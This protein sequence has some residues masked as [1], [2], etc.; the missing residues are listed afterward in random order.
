MLRRR[1]VFSIFTVHVHIVLTSVTGTII[2][3]NNSNNYT[4]DLN[5]AVIILRG[6]IL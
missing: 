6:N 5:L 3:F 2:F 1:K 4:D